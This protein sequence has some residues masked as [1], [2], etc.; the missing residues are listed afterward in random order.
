MLTA[1][2]AIEIFSN[3]MSYREFNLCC[4]PFLHSNKVTL[5]DSNAPISRFWI[6]APPQVLSV[7]SD[8]KRNRA[9]YT[10]FPINSLS[11]S[12]PPRSF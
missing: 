3:L 10:Q 8:R 1:M 9:K 11:V 5:Q 6:S 2:T 12:Y 7:Q 4:L